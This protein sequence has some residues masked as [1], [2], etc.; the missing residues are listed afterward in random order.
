MHKKADVKLYKKQWVLYLVYFY[1]YTCYKR[2]QCNRYLSNLHN[3]VVTNTKRLVI[4]QPLQ[5]KT[6]RPLL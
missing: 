1:I 2:S 6:I 4:Y 5:H 3:L